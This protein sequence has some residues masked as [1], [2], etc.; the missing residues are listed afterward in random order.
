M[1][2]LRIERRFP[3]A[4]DKVFS[5]VTEMENLLKW[6]GPEG[7]GIAEHDL[8][9][10]ELGPW[11]FVII[12]PTGGHHRV[13]GTVLDVSPP[14]YVEFTL[15]VPDG[16]GPPQIDSVVRFDVSP[17]GEGGTFF[18]LTQTGISAEEIIRGSTQGWV[19]TLGRLEKLFENM[20]KG[21]A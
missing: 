12:D 17:D 10:T 21:E 7:T 5:Y 9:F 6:W 16:D 20:Q 1:K 14:H 3:V 11:F 8:D 4:P 15:I 13:T 18:V 19:S 2:E